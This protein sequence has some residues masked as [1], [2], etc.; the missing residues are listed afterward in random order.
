MQP[1][2]MLS[3]TETDVP[4]IRLRRRVRIWLVLVAVG[5]AGVFSIAAWIQPYDE[6]GNA[7]PLGSHTQLGLS[8]CTFERM[9]GK[10][11][12][13]CG[14]TTSFSLLMHGDPRNSL[15]ANWV[16]TIL[17]VTCLLTMAW[18]LI[19]GLRG[20]PFWAYPRERFF[21]LVFGGIGAVALMRWAF[22]MSEPYLS[23]LFG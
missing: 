1:S 16:G 12:A 22:M 14:M 10:P 17:A 20:R 9:T 4:V 11:C 2:T 8:R 21:V 5:L 3:E 6:Q 15:R 19:S 13:S 7:M 18:A 23:D